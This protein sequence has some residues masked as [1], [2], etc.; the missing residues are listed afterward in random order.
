MSKQF[1]S[2]Q[3]LFGEQSGITRDDLRNFNLRINGANCGAGEGKRLGS[4][5]GGLTF[6][7]DKCDITDAAALLIWRCSPY[8]LQ[9]ECR[10]ERVA[11]TGAVRQVN[12]VKNLGEETLTLTEF[13]SA[14]VQGIGAVAGG[15]WHREGRYLLHQVDSSWMTEAQWKSAAVTDLGVLY[16]HG[17]GAWANY[18]ISSTGS[19]STVT[20]YPLVILEDTADGRCFYYE[21]ESGA[22]WQI[23]VGLSTVSDENS[24]YVDGSGCD[25]N[26]DCW[27][28]DL[29]PGEQY[30]A[31][32]AVYGVA[33]GGVDDAIYDLLAYKRATSAADFGTIPV[34]YNCYLNSIFS[35]PTDRRL[36]PLIDRAAEVGA[37]IFC[38]DAGWHHTA[39]DDKPTNMIG[40]WKINN[41]RFG[42]GGL[43]SVISYIKS[44]GMKP[45]IWME[46]DC[47]RSE[48]EA[49]G[50]DDDCLLKRRGKIIGK[51]R[52]FFN[53]RNDK[54]MAHIHS[55]VDMLYSMGIRFIK[56]DYNQ[57]V[58][59]GCDNYGRSYS[60]ELRENYDAWLTLIK[61]IRSKHPDLIIENCASGG[62]RSDGG[63]MRHFELCSFSDQEFYYDYPSL[64]LGNM[65]I[66]PHHK[67]GIWATPCPVYFG[68]FMSGRINSPELQAEKAAMIADG[69]QTVYSMAT[70]ML[71]AMYIGGAIN[72]CDD[73]NMS[74]IKEAVDTYKARRDFIRDAVPVWPC[75]RPVMAH[76]GIYGG[77]LMDKAGKNMLLAVWRVRT[78]EES[79][80]I[81]LSR[82][83]GESSKV[84]L[85]YPA[86]KGGVDYLYD[87]KRAVLRVTMSGSENMCRLF[88]VEI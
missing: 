1:Y 10:Y 82:W 72:L 87:A 42:E 36:Q 70:A 59:I 20:H 68:E 53:F 33:E 74:L 46:I 76:K 39:P 15:D 27:Y 31:P 32:A 22:S 3:W 47:C 12:T 23:E 24:L 60:Q 61:E 79:G 85:L 18:C 44:K 37:E 88:W 4:S 43:Q 86:A 51:D 25:F 49:Y 54:V 78:D 77:G 5:S 81:D 26:L 28:Y 17:S 35:R 41:A 8:S 52:A 30:T 14:F 65:A 69:E 45:G 58:G 40:D 29:A 38:I 6:A 64:V 66:I 9:I 83:C 63:T 62:M 75:G 73:Y 57:N 48:C 2:E 13:S 21:I 7:L 71:G 34:T 16:H 67:L 19:M 55:S 84:S 80:E 56:N 11:G 50:L